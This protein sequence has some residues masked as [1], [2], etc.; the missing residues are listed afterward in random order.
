MTTVAANSNHDLHEDRVMLAQPTGTISRSLIAIFV[1]ALVANAAVGQSTAS[2]R[3]IVQVSVPIG[4][5]DPGCWPYV[6][7]V[8]TV[9]A[10]PYPLNTT[11]GIG[12]LVAPITPSDLNINGGLGT[13]HDHDYIAPHVPRPAD[14]QVTFWFDQP[15]T[16]GAVTLVQHQNGITQIEGFVGNTVNA[17]TSIGSPF[18][19]LGDITGSSVFQEGQVDTFAFPNPVA[20]TILHLVFRKTS[21]PSGWANYR[22][23]PHDLSGALILPAVTQTIPTLG[24]GQGNSATARLEING[25]G[26]GAQQGPF[27]IFV[28]PLA[29]LNFAWSGAPLM[30]LILAAGP[31]NIGGLVIPGFGSVDI[32]T[33]PSFGDISIIFDGANASSGFLFT[34]DPG[35]NAYHTFVIPAGT[36]PGTQIA[37]Q[38]V[39]QQPQ[40]T[41]TFG[42]LVT[43]AFRIDVL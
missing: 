15:T 10:P 34:T 28:A 16:V 30:P 41:T 38:G 2:P 43:A 25:Y 33:P 9:A 39:V 31:L 42:N 5:Q 20:G 17:L 32:G 37:I 26:V 22:V 11:I 36:I 8:Y 7:N 6:D 23:Y 27:V 18:G 40:G 1:L 4:S 21:Y 3:T 29:P 12:H 19:S 14:A 24:G 13:L 35:G